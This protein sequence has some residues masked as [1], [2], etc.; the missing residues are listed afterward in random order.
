MEI[1]KTA[2]E[3]HGLKA[4]LERKT[5]YIGRL[6]RAKAALSDLDEEGGVP[7][8]TRRR[9]CEGEDR[10]SGECCPRFVPY[11]RQDP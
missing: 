5:N 6:N 2:N 1:T 7:K 10:S 3:I 8:N 4:D 9:S 11:P